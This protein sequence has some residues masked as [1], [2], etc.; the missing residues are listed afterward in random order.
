MLV[1]AELCKETHLDAA[2]G[3]GELLGRLLVARIAIAEVHLL[4]RGHLG[5]NCGACADTSEKIINRH[6]GTGLQV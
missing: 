4:T 1:A 5:R 3:G 2:A 6:I